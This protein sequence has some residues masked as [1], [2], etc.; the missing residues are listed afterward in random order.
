MPLDGPAP[1]KIDGQKNASL[2]CE[3]YV[4]HDAPAGTRKGTLRLKAGEQTL[5][6]AVSL[7]VWDFTLPDYLSFLPEMNCYGLPANEREYYRLAHRHRT[8]LNRVPYSQGGNVHDGCAPRWDGKT[9]DWSAWDKRFG[10][11]F[12]GSAFADLPRKSVPMECFYLPIHENWPTAIE[13]NYNGNYWAD[14]AFTQSVS[15]G[16]R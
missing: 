5:D 12:D 10:P 2:Y 7:E 8:V 14:R 13:P 1:E 4:P 16:L 15:P 11:Y 6:L 3:V 9:L